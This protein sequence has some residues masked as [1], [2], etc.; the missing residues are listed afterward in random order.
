MNPRVSI[1]IPVYNV[2]KYLP[3]CLDSV[4]NQSYKNLEIILVDDGS[5]DGSE[6]IVD[7][8]KKKDQRI[9]VVHQKNQGQSGAR[10]TGVKK[11]TGDFVSFIDGDDQIKP[12][13]IKELIKSIEQN[14][15]LAVCGMEYKR[16]KE[17]SVKNVYINKLRPKKRKES[18]KAYMLY[19]LTVDGR[20]YSSVNKLYRLST[21]KNNNLKFQEKL[22]IQ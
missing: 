4:L 10:N 7:E 15:S 1:I 12:S 6:K 9:V 3:E 14:G 18:L 2:K 20:M 11:A 17:N 19:L 22:N 21:I 13:F 16:L 8:Y 5:T